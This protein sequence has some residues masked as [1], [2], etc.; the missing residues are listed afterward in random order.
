MWILQ[1]DLRKEFNVEKCIETID[2]NDARFRVKNI[3]NKLCNSEI[4]EQKGYSTKNSVFIGHL[5]LGDHFCLSGAIRYLSLDWDTMY[6]LCKPKNL[7]N[8]Q[9]LYDDTP[10]IQCVSVKNDFQFPEIN[11]LSFEK[12]YKSGLYCDS[13]QEFVNL[14]NCFYKD[15]G[16]DPDIQSKYFWVS[17]PKF[18]VKITVPYIF[19]HQETSSKTINL[20]QWD[21]NEI[22]TIDPN[23]NLYPSDHPWHKRAGVCV[24]HLV[25]D[26]SELLIG[27]EQVHLMDSCF[28]CFA[29]YLPL[30]A[31]VKICYERESGQPSEI[32][33]F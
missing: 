11:T 18:S 21:I 25:A 28:Y 27:A 30:K 3:I 19:V 10:N 23:K 32:Y 17:P 24:G 31:T 1:D 13:H 12:I 15:L 4:Q 14:P 2:K 6:V 33:K 8:V 9:R 26:Y 5:G 16:L 22:L 20:I 29:R 7:K